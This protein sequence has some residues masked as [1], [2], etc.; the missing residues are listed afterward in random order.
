ME[1]RRRASKE[2]GLQLV[3][4]AY[5]ECMEGRIFGAP[6]FS[7]RLEM[8]EKILFPEPIWRVGV[9]FLPRD[10][11]FRLGRVDKFTSVVDFCSF[12]PK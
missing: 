4:I 1:L 8:A 2:D 6:D 5:I 10:T 3:I 12:W 11:R 7:K 9:S